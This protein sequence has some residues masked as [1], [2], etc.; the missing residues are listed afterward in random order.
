MSWLKE[1]IIAGWVHLIIGIFIGY[2]VFEKPQWA[3]DLT[4]KLLVK[5]HLKSATPSA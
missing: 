1:W 4:D 5:L 2:L 3:K